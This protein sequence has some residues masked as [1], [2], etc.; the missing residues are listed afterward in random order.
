MKH[1]TIA[2]A[3]AFCLSLLWAGTP[4]TV[5]ALENPMEESLPLTLSERSVGAEG[6]QLMGAVELPE[7]YQG[8]QFRAQVYAANEDTEFEDW[9]LYSF[10]DQ[11][12]ASSSRCCLIQAAD[13]Y[14]RYLE[15]TAFTISV[16][17]VLSFDGGITLR[18]E[19]DTLR[20]NDTAETVQTIAAVQA[21]PSQTMLKFDRTQTPKFWTEY[22]MTAVTE[23]TAS[24]PALLYCDLPE[25]LPI[26]LDLYPEG[27]TTPLEPQLAE[28]T[29]IWEDTPTVLENGCLRYQA[30][31]LTP[32]TQDLHV[33]SGNNHYVLE[34]S[35]YPKDLTRIG[36]C[37]T[38]YCIVHPVTRGT[39]PRL[40]LSSDRGL[41]DAVNGT[42]SLK[43]TGA[44]G[45]T[46][47]TSVDGGTT[48]KAAGEF[49]LQKIDAI[50]KEESCTAQI[51][52]A[53]AVS[54]LLDE[55]NGGFLV[56]LRIIG[57]ALGNAQA[58]GRLTYTDSETA[59]WPTDYEYTP[60]K[61]PDDSEGSGGNTGNVGS[62]N[63]GTGGVRPGRVTPDTSQEPEQKIPWN[64]PFRDVAETAW[65]RE[66]VEFVY[67][68]GWMAGTSDT[69]FQPQAETTRAMVVSILY[70]MAGRPKTAAATVMHDVPSGAYYAAA[71]EW[72]VTHKIVAG[73]GGGAFG[74][75][76]AVTR[77]QLITMLWKYAGSPDSSGS[78]NRYR[79]GDSVSA[80]AKT[81]MVWA[82]EQG[83]L[84]GTSDDTLSP[85]GQATRAQVAQ[86][87][88]NYMD[89][90]R[91]PDSGGTN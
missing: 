17:L 19:T 61:D 37:T 74:P 26:Q 60:P 57:G 32:P 8:R 76:D 78:L 77:E 70:Q 20:R 41:R 55:G 39:Q 7:E 15:G 33:T 35:R 49:D 80:Y 3:L 51:L 1:R 53:E 40:L 75:N 69:E 27:S 79:D 42:L 9:T 30:L 4:M 21:G 24:G 2:L 88:K 63:K 62:G 58:A 6:Y 71:V 65:Y 68:N 36:Y 54:A 44:M 72:A 22:H 85:R 47:F 34:S 86:I 82:T 16:Y 90:Q 18:T 89:A 38:W 5:L 67:T 83:I 73:Y 48:W 64:N 45:I 14:R 29:V 50:P 81:A 23:E 12:S 13:V 31:E 66:A 43:P 52:T 56:K 28:Y 11:P 91:Q 84:R 25:T 87:L 10:W 46:V 59:A